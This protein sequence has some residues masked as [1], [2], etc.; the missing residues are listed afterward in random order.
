MIKFLS[1]QKHSPIFFRQFSEHAQKKTQYI[2]DKYTNGEEN[3]KASFS[4]LC[5][6]NVAPVY[7]EDVMKPRIRVK[8]K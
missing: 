5:T 3:I 1:K 4:K 7:Q 2:A 8:A 6:G